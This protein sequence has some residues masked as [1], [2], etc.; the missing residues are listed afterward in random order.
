MIELIVLI[1]ETASAPPFCAARAGGRMSVMFGVS[2]TIT[3]SVAYSLHPAR[4]HL[5]V[6]GHL[7]DR[8][9]HAAL[10][11]AVRAAEVQLEAVGAGVLDRSAGS[12]A[13]PPLRLT[14]SDT[15]TAWFG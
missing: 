9:A 3:G 15:I 7:A 10:A 12:L 6:L 2:F 1:S 5:D 8:R 4:D 11:H 14:I 13:R